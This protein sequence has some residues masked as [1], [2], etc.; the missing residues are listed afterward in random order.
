VER[1]KTAAEETKK[2]RE[3]KEDRDVGKRKY[4]C[5]GDN[6]TKRGRRKIETWGRKKRHLLKIKRN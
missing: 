5:R 2:V 4:I 3:R 6:E 1:K